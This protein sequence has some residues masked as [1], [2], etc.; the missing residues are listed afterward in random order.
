MGDICCFYRFVSNM[1]LHFLCSFA[2]KVEEE[3]TAAARG[4]GAV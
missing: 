2:E 1:T 4:R 3:E